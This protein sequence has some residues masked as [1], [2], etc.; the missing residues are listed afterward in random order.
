[1][2][3]DASNL[4]LSPIVHPGRCG[5]AKCVRCLFPDQQDAFAAA[6]ET[7]AQESALQVSDFH[8][9]IL[10]RQFRFTL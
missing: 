10:T 7:T 5:E 8:D 2:A 6:G 3:T 9:Q 4:I 1:M